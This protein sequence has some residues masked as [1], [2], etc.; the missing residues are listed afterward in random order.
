MVETQQPLRFPFLLATCHHGHRPVRTSVTLA[1]LRGPHRT[2]DRQ[3]LAAV[4]AG[5]VL[6]CRR[7]LVRGRCLRRGVSAQ[8]ALVAD[9]AVAQSMPDPVQQIRLRA[10]PFVALRR[11][12]D[13]RVDLAA[14]VALE[15]EVALAG[16]PSRPLRPRGS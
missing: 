1:R 9:G 7:R 2:I 5:V 15:Q 12:L 13:E 16:A 10:R 6:H 4:V 14:L 8:R 3:Q 11:P